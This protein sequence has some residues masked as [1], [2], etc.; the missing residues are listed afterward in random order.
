MFTCK[1]EGLGVL[2]RHVVQPR[3][4][5]LIAA[6]QL[7]W[8]AR[9]LLRLAGVRL[10]FRLLLLQSQAPISTISAC[11]GLRGSAQRMPK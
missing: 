7:P 8:V 5:H 3:L 2:L 11:L 6:L 9:L 4:P 1:E 10:C